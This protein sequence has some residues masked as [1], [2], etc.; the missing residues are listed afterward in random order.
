MCC[1]EAISNKRCT[2]QRLTLPFQTCTTPSVPVLYHLL[3][4]LLTSACTKLVMG[5][6]EWLL[7]LAEVPEDVAAADAAP[8]VDA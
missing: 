8:G 7:L 5:T 1:Q 2:S 3:G 6:L 4:V